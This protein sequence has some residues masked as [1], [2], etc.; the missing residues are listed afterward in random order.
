GSDVSKDLSFVGIEP[1][2]DKAI[3]DKIS[4]SLESFA[5]QENLNTSSEATP[6]FTNET[7]QQEKSTVG[8]NMP[9]NEETTIQTQPSDLQ[10][11]ESQPAV[12]EAPQ[13]VAEAPQPVA[14]TPQPV[15]E[16]PQSSAFSKPFSV[17]DAISQIQATQNTSN[18]NLF[19]INVYEFLV[20]ERLEEFQTMF[21][22]CTCPRCCAD[23]T[24]VALTNLPAKYIVTEDNKSLPLLSFYRAKFSTA[25]TA[26]LSNACIVVKDKPFH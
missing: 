19:Y 22:V 17:E 24:A 11:A 23:V 3:S 20:R 15:A 14:E 2:N 5:D 16:T 8:E 10:S 21:D 1:S 4:E 26:Q 25:V 7:T 9:N 6:T 18:T 13:P 12:A